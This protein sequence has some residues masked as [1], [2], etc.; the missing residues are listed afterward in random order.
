MCDAPTSEDKP[1]CLDHLDHMKGPA[2]VLAELAAQQ[3]RATEAMV[4]DAL[5]YLD[6]HGPTAQRSLRLA[7][8]WTKIQAAAVV[9]EMKARGV[10]RHGRSRS[11]ASVLILCDPPT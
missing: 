9:R 6:A 10:V 3:S 5:L 4:G 8:K 11:G 1:Y 2:Q 7:M